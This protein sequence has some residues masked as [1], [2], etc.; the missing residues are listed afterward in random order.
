MGR[1][2]SANKEQQKLI[3]ELNQ[4]ANDCPPITQREE[5]DKFQAEFLQPIRDAI[6]KAGR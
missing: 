5:F 4:K 1:L 2:N 6:I 3:R